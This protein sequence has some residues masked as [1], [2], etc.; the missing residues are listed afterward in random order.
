MA[1][2]SYK[3]GSSYKSSYLSKQDWRNLRILLFS[4]IGTGAVL[5]LFYLFL[6][7]IAPNIDV[8]WSAIRPGSPAP[9]ETQDRIPP[10]P[11]QLL[12]L[13]EATDQ[14]TL[15]ISGYAEPGAKVVLHLNESKTSEVVVDKE[16]SFT[17]ESIT[18]FDGENRIEVETI[19]EAGNVCRQP[20]TH[21]IIFD[22]EEPELTVDQPKEG[23]EF[24]GKDKETIT[25]KG[26]TEPDTK[27][28]INGQ[29]V[30]VGEEGNFE[31]SLKLEEGDNQIEIIAEN[32]A[33][34][35]TKQEITVKYEA[36]EED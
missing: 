20:A 17:F 2:K 1:R 28:T 14:D 16:G 10:A 6:T 27:I 31:H 25:I 30:R 36:P 19:D 22:E 15:N 8:F 32:K 26:M 33:G 3:K 7:R 18:L 21:T 34:N 11:P 5:T 24:E 12:T 29:W 23:E 4:L 35:E 9:A 13:P